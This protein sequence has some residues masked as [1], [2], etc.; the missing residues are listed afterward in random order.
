MS[1]KIAMLRLYKPALI[2]PAIR[3]LSQDILAADDTSEVGFVVLAGIDLGKTTVVGTRTCSA[4]AE[5]DFAADFSVVVPEPIDAYA[6]VEYQQAVCLWPFAAVAQ[7]AAEES[8]ATLFDSSVAE[9]KFVAL[10]AGLSVNVVED[11]VAV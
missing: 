3:Y 9:L 1:R 11:W 8:V 2:H 6:F 5:V 7:N 10:A 4:F